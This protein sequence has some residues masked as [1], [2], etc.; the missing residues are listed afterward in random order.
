M[1]LAPIGDESITVST[2]SVGFTTAEIT[3][4]VLMARVQHLSGGVLY[5]RNTGTAAND[6]SNGEFLLN[7]G[8][9]IEVWG[10]R[11]LNAIRWIKK[12]GEDDGVISVQYMG[13]G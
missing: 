5:Y 9:E 12:S 3:S 11:A 2:S 1:A 10:D 13:E 8:E 7:N 4:K 6:A